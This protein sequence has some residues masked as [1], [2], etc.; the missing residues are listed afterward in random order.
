MKPPNTLANLLEAFFNIFMLTGRHEGVALPLLHM[1]TG[2]TSHP[3]LP[4][5][6]ASIPP[7]FDRLQYSKLGMSSVYICSIS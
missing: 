4:H 5:S 3:A 6:Q 1:H 2:G 7:V